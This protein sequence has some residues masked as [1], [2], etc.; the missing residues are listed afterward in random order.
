MILSREP[1]YSFTYNFKNN[2]YKKLYLFNY[3]NK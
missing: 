2:K 1:V 3:K